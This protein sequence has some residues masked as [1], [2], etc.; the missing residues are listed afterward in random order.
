MVRASVK[1]IT[2]GSRSSRTTTNRRAI[3]K[4]ANMLKRRMAGTPRAPLATRG[5]WGQYSGRGRAELKYKDTAAANVGIPATWNLILLNGIA[6]GTDYTER[7]GRQSTMKSILFN[8]NTFP[9]TTM[10]ANAYQGTMVRFAII[11]DTQPNGVAP[12]GTDIFIA[13]TTLSPINLVNRDRFRVL[14][15]V[16]KQIGSFLLTATPALSAGSPAN[17]YWSKYKKCNL[18]EQFSGT[19]NTISSI[20]TGALYL[21]FISDNSNVCMYDYHIRVRYTDA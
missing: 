17:T 11:Y 8:G 20:S 15:D 10:S 6:Q 9:T 12:A 13:N 16:R 7:I 21:L 18:D 3:A 14:M 4:A 19:A 2:Y 5:F 1:T